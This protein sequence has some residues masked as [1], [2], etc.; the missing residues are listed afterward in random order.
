MVVSC[1]FF[2]F[3]Q[4]VGQA[5]WVPAW[6]ALLPLHATDA[7][8]ELVL[9]VESGAVDVRA[10]LRL[11]TCCGVN[12]LSPNVEIAHVTLTTPT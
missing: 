11:T 4:R 6:L 8:G 12:F 2:V 1:T 9:S 3:Y 7:R 10:C 5:R